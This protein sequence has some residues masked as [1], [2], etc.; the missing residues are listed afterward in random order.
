MCLFVRASLLLVAVIS[1]DDLNKPDWMWFQVKDCIEQL[2]EGQM[3]LRTRC[4]E[5][6]GYTERKEPYQD[7]S[8]AIRKETDNQYDDDDDEEEEEKGQCPLLTST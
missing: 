5:C 3:A 7:I 1:E 6:E 2:F 8:V 4:L